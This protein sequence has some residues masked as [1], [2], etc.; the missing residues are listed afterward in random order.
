MDTIEVWGGVFHGVHRGS[1]GVYTHEDGHTYA[2]AHEGAMAHGYGVLK[3]S[4][5]NTYSGQFANGRSH[6]HVEVY[7]PDGD[8][9]YWLYEH[10]KEVHCAHVKPNGA[11]DYDDERCGADHAGLVALKA[12]AQRAGVRNT[13]I[14]ARKRPDTCAR[15]HVLCM[16]ICFRVRAR[17][18]LCGDL[19]VCAGVCV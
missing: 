7:W 11:C 15:T 14:P 6:G 8:V 19:C 4:V 18:F 9:V 12:T 13:R 5:G 3:G 1:V 2:G 10:G 17:T 16:C